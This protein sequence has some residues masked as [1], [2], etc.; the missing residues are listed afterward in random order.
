MFIMLFINRLKVILRNKSVLFWSLIFP[1]VLGTFFHLALSDVGEAYEMNDIPLAIVND[2]NYIYNQNFDNII[3]SL[4]EGDDRIFDIQYTD[5]D[6][7]NS[8]LEESKI[9]GYIKIDDNNRISLLIKENG[10]N[11]TIIK[12]VIDEYYQMSSVLNNIANFNPDK[13]KEGIFN[14]AYENK[15][16][17]LDKSN[18]KIDFSINYFFTLIAMTCLYGSFLGLEIAK[19]SEANLSSRGARLCVSPVNKIKVILAG[20]CASLVVEIFSIAL[21]FAYLILVFNVNLGNHLFYTGLLTFFGVI[22]GILMGVFVGVSNRKSEDFKTGVVLSITMGC[23]FFSG[24]MGTPDIKSYFD[25]ALPLFAK[26]NPINMITDGLY[27][28]FAYNTFEPYFEV[29]FRIIIFT[30]ILLLLV[31]I[32]VRRKKYDSL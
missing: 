15:E 5:I 11:Q 6:K 10:L 24:M 3:S 7:A 2:K 20:L 23:C 17:V 14:L 32:F 29:L 19:D 30:L 9:D 21:L 22:L 4:S 12:Y 31:Y 27:S 25:N 18:E 16:Y 28:L 13:L 1:F 26:I 8:L